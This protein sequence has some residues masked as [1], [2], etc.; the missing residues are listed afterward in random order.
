MNMRPLSVGEILDAGFKLYFRNW[1]KLAA[2]VAI[3]VVPVQ[4][5]NA[6]VRES[7]YKFVRDGTPY[8]L[9]SD[10]GAY[11]AGQIVILIL[12]AIVAL[13]VVAAAFRA[14][15]EAYLGHSPSVGASLR[16]AVGK[17]PSLLWLDILI[18][19]GVVLG[20]VLIIIP[21]IFAYVLWSVSVPVLM[22]EGLKGTSAI[23]RSRELV[24]GRWWATF[25]VLLVSVLLTQVV[26]FVVARVVSDAFLTHTN[27][28]AAYAI[29]VALLT[30]ASQVLL[31]PVV[32]AVTTV[33]YFDLRVRKEG[34]DL[35]QMIDAL[36]LPAQPGAAPAA[37]A[38]G[39]A[40]L[41]GA[42]PPEP[43]WDPPAAPQ[44]GLPEDPEPAAG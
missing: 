38:F 40:S 41:P 7:T 18:I 32:V 31:L 13:L 15:S 3:V 34:F 10:K 25:A 1:T 16:F 44:V 8:Y 30:I 19:L 5:I 42:G 4:I 20:L 24:T 27:S 23:G 29:V 2:T 14:V 26:A 33:L 9:A 21:G 43:S 28:V 17:L 37:A 12:T 36:G 39:G 22:V 11:Q 6:V 35:S